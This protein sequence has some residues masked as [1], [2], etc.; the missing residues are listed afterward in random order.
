MP[1][2]RLL[3]LDVVVWFRLW[4][5]GRVWSPVVIGPTE[6]AVFLQEIMPAADVLEQPAV[7]KATWG[8]QQLKNNSLRLF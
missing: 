1:P 6:G 3:I 4:D 5:T 8:G 2:L 7:V